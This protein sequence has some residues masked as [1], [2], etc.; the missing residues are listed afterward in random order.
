[1]DE[2]VL[3]S[4]SSPCFFNIHSIVLNACSASA[5]VYVRC[6]RVPQ[7]KDSMLFMQGTELI[8]SANKLHI[9]VL[10]VS[11]QQSERNAHFRASSRKWR[12]YISKWTLAKHPSWVFRLWSKS[13]HNSLVKKASI[14]STITSSSQTIEQLRA[15]RVLDELPLQ[16]S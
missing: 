11:R 1:M 16:K 14:A 8:L 6:K 7:E 12:L 2:G 4:L 10:L 5:N 9:L 15:L 13:V 3:F